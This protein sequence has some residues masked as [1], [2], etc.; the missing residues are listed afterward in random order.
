MKKKL[1]VMFVLLIICTFIGF[2]FEIYAEEHPGRKATLIDK[3][4]NKSEVYV[5]GVKP[6]FQLKYVESPLPN[7]FY[8]S[9]STFDYCIPI[10]AVVSIELTPKTMKLDRMAEL[11]VYRV[12]YILGNSNFKVEGIFPSESSKNILLVEL[13]SNHAEIV[14][15]D[16]S[17]LLFSDEPKAFTLFSKHENAI[18]YIITLFDDTKIEAKNIYFHQEN[19]STEGYIVGGTYV[20]NFYPFFP[21]SKGALNLEIKFNKIHSL[22][23][24]PIKNDI[25]PDWY[26]E[27]NCELLLTDKS[28]IYGKLV[29]I[30]E[31]S[32]FT[33]I[34]EKGPFFVE[35]R[36]IKAIDLLLK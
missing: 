14:M 25:S 34:T 23:L 33:R 22:K 20:Q 1:R 7:S 10:D 6:F 12:E 31:F 13:G 27:F 2:S 18:S 28:I 32:G 3:T 15:S 26:Y 24:S 21:I 9:T 30:Y 36:K 4:G 8:L 11:P 17:K 29:K 35:V 19:Y 5:K 16:I